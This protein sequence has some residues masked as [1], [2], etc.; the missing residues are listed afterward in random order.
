MRVWIGTAGYSYPDWVGPFYPAGTR[1]ARMLA[2]YA[3]H[4]PAVELNFTFYRPPTAAALARLADQ[5]PPGFQFV[6]KATGT[7]TH[8]QSEADLPG[9]RAAA[10]ALRARGR[11]LGVLCQFPQS[12]HDGP[13]SRAWV[14]RLGEGLRGLSPAAEFRHRSW[15]KP[16][17]P[18]WLARNGLDLVS[19]DVPDLPGLYPRGLVRGGPRAYVRFHSRRAGHWYGAHHRRYDYGYCDEELAEWVG[20]LTGPD[21]G[22]ERAVLVFNNCYRTQAVESARRMAQLIRKTAPGVELVG[23]LPGVRTEAE[24]PGLFDQA[25]HRGAS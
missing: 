7:L 8:E 20:P 5:T 6:V 23:P 15:A 14:E 24:Q 1:P 11:L 4:F 3:R 10:E 13:K 19:V 2:Y 9:F 21:A 17:V 25:G 12:M 22:F 16:A 18:G